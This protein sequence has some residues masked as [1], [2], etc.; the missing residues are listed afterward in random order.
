MTEGVSRV[1]QLASEINDVIGNQRIRFIDIGVC[2]TDSV[3]LGLHYSFDAGEFKIYC[4]PYN[5]SLL[6]IYSWPHSLSLSHVTLLTT[7]T[8]LSHLARHT[9]PYLTPLTS[10]L[11]LSSLSPLISSSNLPFT[12][13]STHLITGGGLSV[14]Y[15]SDDVTPTF[16]EYAE[17]LRSACPQ[18]F[19]SPLGDGPA[20]RL[21]VITGWHSRRY[22]TWCHVMWYDIVWYEVMWCD[23]TWFDLT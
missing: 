15:S 18:L 4:L 2:G 7:H 3:L 9:S 21:T 8:S 14:N 12:S 11:P 20:Q 1:V 17:A 6:S 10:Y 23:V 16:T 19:D 5:L 22:V 13:F